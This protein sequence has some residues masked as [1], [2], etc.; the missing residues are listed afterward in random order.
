MNTAAPKINELIIKESDTLLVALDRIT[1]TALGIAFVT[2]GEGKLTGVLADGDIRRALLKGVTLE[3]PVAQVMFK[4]FTAF[5]ID[6]PEEEVFKHLSGKIQFIPLLDDQG[7]PVDYASLYRMHQI[8]VMEPELG[9]NEIP[10]VMECLKTNWISSKGKYVREFENLFG[11]HHSGWP[12]LSVSNG[13]VAL[14][15]ALTA[16]GIGPGDEVILPDLTFAAS[17]NAVLYTGATPV[18]V[19]VDPRY[20]TL[21]PQK[22]EAALTPKTKAIMPVHLYGHPCD[23]DPIM[24]LA[25]KHQLL[26]IEDCAEALGALY[27]GQ[28]VGTLGD[29]GC[30]SFFGNKLITTGEGGMVVFKDKSK[31]DNAKLLRDHGMDPQKV[32]WHPK[33]GYNYRLT[34]LQAAVGLAQM[35]Q[36][37]RFIGKKLAMSSAYKAIFIDIKGITTPQQAPWAKNV[38]WLYTIQLGSDVKLNRDEFQFKLL[39]NGIETRPIFYPLHVMPPYEQFARGQKFPVSD[40]IS[41]SGLSL[42]S[43]VS[44]TEKEFE[45]VKETIQ[46]IVGIKKLFE[47]IT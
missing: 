35:E 42:P 27:K 47:T 40:R 25:R 14:H 45:R 32:Y 29:A 16:L 2:N 19:D 8:P 9:G 3:S 15:L 26:I 46:R 38:Y 36:L 31:Y 22:I 34:N 18:L 13:T 4:K 39:Q 28:P 30:F 37:D 33:V 43:S 6:T 17:A 12:S 24:E 21:D 23:M 7:R 44:L 10:Y 11:Q 20:W 41:Q 5:S 1:Q